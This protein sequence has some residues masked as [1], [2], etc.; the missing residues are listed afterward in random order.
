M[1]S[2]VNKTIGLLRKLQ[3]I[4]QRESLIT[5]CK[6]FIRPHVDYGDVIY[7]EAYNFLF[8]QCIEF[9]QYNGSLA[10]VGAIRGTSKREIYQE[11]GF[12]SLQQRRWY[13]KLCCL[14]RIIK[15]RSQSY[16]FQ[17]VPSS[18]SRYLTRNS[19][20]IPQIC[21]KLNFFKEILFS[22]NYK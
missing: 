15:N 2:K 11:L 1:P 16:L 13:R 22:L 10:M 3:N 8:Y 7:D 20:N 14:I 18:S 6:S 9:V 21:T 5:I 17:L 19:D 12:E 4:S